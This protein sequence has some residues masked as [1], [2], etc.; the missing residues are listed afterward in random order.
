MFVIARA[1]TYATLFIS[2]ILIYVPAQLLSWSGII[3]P[4]T[5]EVQQII[6]MI[7]GVIGALIALW[8]VF[9]FATIGG[10]TPAPFDPPRRLVIRG[11]Y[12]FVR[13]PMYI[14]AG[15][16]LA[17]AALFYES[18]VLVL[19]LCV[20]FLVTHLFVIWYEEPTLRQN[21]REE[22]EAYCRLVRRWLPGLTH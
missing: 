20:F 1:I 4:S 3:R 18:T 16:A 15:L 7:V 22:Y 10:G 12:H 8:C 13:N 11:P 9:T 6:G 19:Y 17:G 5:I 14:G 21:F 2:L